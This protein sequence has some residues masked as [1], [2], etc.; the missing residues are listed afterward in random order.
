MKV[1]IK[2]KAYRLPRKGRRLQIGTA[3]MEVSIVLYLQAERFI[4]FQKNTDISVLLQ[5]EEEVV[6]EQ[7]TGAK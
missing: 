1:V 6:S 7:N 3:T 4:Y 5:Q 2:D